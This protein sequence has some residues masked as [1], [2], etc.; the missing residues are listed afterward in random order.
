MV[1]ACLP[2]AACLPPAACGEALVL[3]QC[4]SA[5]MGKLI[6][7][8]WE[9]MLRQA[10]KEQL[11]DSML[12]LLAVLDGHPNFPQFEGHI[13]R[14]WHALAHPDPPR[15]AVHQFRMRMSRLLAAPSHAEQVQ[16]TGPS[17]RPLEIADRF[18]RRQ[19]ERSGRGDMEE[20]RSRSRSPRSTSRARQ[21]R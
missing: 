6:L 21:G 14:L 16:L 11:V 10:S 1:G 18:R 4:F 20:R 5:N 3:N 13:F 15:S 2:A 17:A 19:E 7:E 12:F 9:T 8:Q